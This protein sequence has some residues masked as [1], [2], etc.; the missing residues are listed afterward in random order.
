MDKAFVHIGLY[1]HLFITVAEIEMVKNSIFFE[2]FAHPV[3][4]PWPTWLAQCQNVRRSVPQIRD[5]T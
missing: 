2:L 3:E 5:R 1:M 4:T